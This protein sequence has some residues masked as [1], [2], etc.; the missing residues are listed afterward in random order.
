[1]KVEPEL[2]LTNDGQGVTIDKLDI[3][4]ENSVGGNH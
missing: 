2:H 3:R 1:M 4:P